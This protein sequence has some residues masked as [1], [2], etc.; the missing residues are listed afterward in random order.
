MLWTILLSAALPDL[1]APRFERL[2]AEWC[3]ANAARVQERC[4][5]RQTTSLQRF[6]A[7]RQRFPGEAQRTVTRCL[8]GG[9]RSP[10]VDWVAAARC[11]DARASVR[12]EKLIPVLAGGSIVPPPPA[13]P[14]TPV[15]PQSGR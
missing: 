3:S 5:E 9:A 4:R 11:L 7:L 10:S 14:W 8:Q 15:L 13:F 12:A 2:I 1:H 6:L